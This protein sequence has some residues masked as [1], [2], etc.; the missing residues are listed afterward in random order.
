MKFAF[1]VDTL[2]RRWSYTADSRLKSGTMRA[3]DSKDETVSEVV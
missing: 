2:A 3:A 1:A